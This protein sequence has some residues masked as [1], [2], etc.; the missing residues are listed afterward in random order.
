MELTTITMVE[1]STVRATHTIDSAGAIQPFLQMLQTPGF[2]DDNGINPVS[3]RKHVLVEARRGQKDLL[4]VLDLC[5]DETTATRAGRLKGESNGIAA[6]LGDLRTLVDQLRRHTPGARI[7]GTR[8]CGLTKEFAKSV[9]NFQK[10][11]MVFFCNGAGDTESMSR[12]C[13]QWKAQVNTGVAGGAVVAGGAATAGGI[14]HM[15]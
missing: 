1:K 4:L 10:V 13:N 14:V 3:S 6:D 12:L 15:E 8:V 5:G 2:G 9:N 11:H 7:F